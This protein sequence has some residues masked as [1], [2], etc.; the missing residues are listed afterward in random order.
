MGTIGFLIFGMPF[1]NFPMPLV[2]YNTDYKTV[3]LISS[4]HSG[5]EDVWVR[6]TLSTQWLLGASILRHVVL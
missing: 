2:N 5:V 1:I 3:V 4:H 6:D